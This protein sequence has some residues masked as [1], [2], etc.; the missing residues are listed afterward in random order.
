MELEMGHVVKSGK[1]F[2]CHELIMNAKNYRIDSTEANVR[3]T[4]FV[5]EVNNR[6]LVRL[7]NLQKKLRRTKHYSLRI[8][9]IHTSFSKIV[10]SK[11]YQE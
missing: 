7:A 9:M 6:F 8:P 10:S 3:R 1:T 5:V 11:Y 4:M 2:G